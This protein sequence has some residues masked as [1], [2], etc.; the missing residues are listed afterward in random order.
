MS[1]RAAPVCSNVSNPALRSTNSN[2]RFKEE[3]RA[4][5]ILRPAGITSLPIPSP[6]IRPK[7]GEFGNGNTLIVSI[8]VFLTYP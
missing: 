7:R 5:R 2:L 8:E 1:G 4:S 3:G 6:G